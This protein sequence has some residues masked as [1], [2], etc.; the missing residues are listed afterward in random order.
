ME[1]YSSWSEPEGPMRAEAG[2]ARREMTDF[3]DEFVELFHRHF[4]RLHRVLDRLS[5]DPDLAADLAQETFV[6]LYRRGAPPDAPEA[7]LVTVGLNLLRNAR[8]TSVRRQR[9]LSDREAAEA[10]EARVA[11]GAHASECTPA[12]RRVCAALDQ[13]P[14]RERRILLLRAEGYS[15]REI[16]EVLALKEASIGTLLARAKQAF[17]EL[18]GETSDAS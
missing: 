14:G 3:H 18:Y 6:R 7:W 15:Y 2:R 11:G 9:L 8:S 16:A 17:R 4:G 12:R 10:E 13:M 1:G 5:G